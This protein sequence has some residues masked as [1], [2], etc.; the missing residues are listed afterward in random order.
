M[1][2]RILG[3]MGVDT[4]RTE[5]H[6]QVPK[7]TAAAAETREDYFAPS[8]EDDHRFSAPNLTTGNQGLLRRAQVQE[9]SWVNLHCSMQGGTGCSHSRKSDCPV[10]GEFLGHT[11]EFVRRRGLHDT[12]QKTLHV[13]GGNRIGNVR[14]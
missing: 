2:W 8:L 1:S 11:A 5:R 3:S 13:V 12:V 14:L 9:T 6:W 10:G 7:V 4:T